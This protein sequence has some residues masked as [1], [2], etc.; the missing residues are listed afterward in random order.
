MT[1]PTTTQST[2]EWAAALSADD[3]ETLVHAC[4]KDGDAKGVD[5]ALRLLTTKDPRRA[6]TLFDTIRLGLD[7][8][9]VG[10]GNVAAQLHADADADQLMT[11]W[12]A[13]GAR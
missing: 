8:A 11:G 10:V 3:C 13:G 2:R 7:I 9:A 1:E 5:A 4:L 6:Q 12:A